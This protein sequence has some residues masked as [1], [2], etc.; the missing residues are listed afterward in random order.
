MSGIMFDGHDFVEDVIAK[1]VKA[2]VH[3]KPIEHMHKGVAYIQVENVNRTLN[4]IASLFYQHPSRYM[5]V[6]GVTGTRMEK[7]RLPV[8]FKMFIHIFTL[9]VISVRLQFAMVM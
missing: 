4:R 3:A 5:K 7:V 8:L 9:A 6:F 2:I 1:G